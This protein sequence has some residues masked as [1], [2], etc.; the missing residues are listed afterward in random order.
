MA[1]ENLKLQAKYG[2]IGQFT[3]GTL[4]EGDDATAL[5]V[6]E[7]VVASVAATSSGLG[8]SSPVTGIKITVQDGETITPATGDSLYPITVTKMCEITGSS[9]EISADELDATTLCDA[10]DGG[11]RVYEKGLQDITGTIDGLSRATDVITEGGINNKFFMIAT[12][13]ADGLSTQIKPVSEGALYLDIVINAASKQGEPT[14]G[15]LMPV[16]L[17]STNINQT[18]GELQTFTTSIRP[19]SDD[20]VKIHMYSRLA[21]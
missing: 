10:F 7:Y 8:L 13:S 18:T 16:E 15:Y 6:G 12:Q 11:F 4:I 2:Y 5:P 21:S 17:F 9:I 3:F 14:S 1:N 20:K 19:T